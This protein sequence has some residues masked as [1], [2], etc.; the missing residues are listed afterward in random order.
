MA[1]QEWGRRPQ[2]STLVSR[3]TNS[4]TGTQMTLIEGILIVS[5]LLNAYTIWRVTKTENEIEMLY[6]GVAMCMTKLG[7]TND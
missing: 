5:L 1:I 7:M 3:S 6:E 4:T 2:E